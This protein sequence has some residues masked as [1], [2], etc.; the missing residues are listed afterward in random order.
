LINDGRAFAP[1][2]LAFGRRMMKGNET[3]V[4]FGGQTM[5]HAKVRLDESQTPIAI[6]YLD[7]G[8]KQLTRG[9]LEVKGPLIRFCM[10]PGGGSRPAD[11]SC[12]VGSG[13]ILSEWKKAQTPR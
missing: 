3:E 8:R 6:D 11:F 13:R 5:V 7:V 9:I 2:M 12:E 1:Q 10:G 4:V